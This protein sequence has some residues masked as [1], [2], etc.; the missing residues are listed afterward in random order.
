[1]SIFTHRWKPSW[2]LQPRSK[3]KRPIFQSVFT[4]FRHTKPVHNHCRAGRKTQQNH[5]IF[6]RPSQSFPRHH[7]VPTLD[8]AEM[9]ANQSADRYTKPGHGAWPSV[10]R[11]LLVEPT[12]PT[13][14]P[15]LSSQNALTPWPM[16]QFASACCT[17]FQRSGR[18]NPPEAALRR[19][20]VF[21]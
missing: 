15:H 8:S 9:Q 13:F 10:W 3:S 19:I 16:A 20:I 5:G 2:S 6:G 14:Q 17:T 1:M 18:K 11:K 7:F 4:C 21:A 12:L